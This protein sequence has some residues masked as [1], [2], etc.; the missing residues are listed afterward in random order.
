VRFGAYNIDAREKLLPPPEAFTRNRR[1][2]INDL[3]TLLPAFRPAVE[4]VLDGLRDDGHEPL[5]WETRRDLKRAAMLKKRGASKSGKKSLHTLDAAVDI[6]CGR[7]YW[8]CDD[9]G[10]SFFDDLGDEVRDE[11]LVWGGNWRTFVDEPHVQA[12][13]V[14]LQRQLRAALD[15]HERNK[16]VEG[17]LSR[18]G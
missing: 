18:H 16:L 8:A 12:V 13:P 1:G 2:I 14:K 10:C 4:R 15:R 9:H 7:H 6:I 5:V 11:G 3:R 17:W